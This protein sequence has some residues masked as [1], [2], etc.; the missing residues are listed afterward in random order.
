MKRVEKPLLVWKM[1]QTEVFCDLLFYVD[2][3]PESSIDNPNRPNIPSDDKPIEKPDA[4]ENL[5]GTL[6]FE[7]IWPDGGRL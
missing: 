2:A 7:D 5:K 4:Q 3:S 6:A 1:E